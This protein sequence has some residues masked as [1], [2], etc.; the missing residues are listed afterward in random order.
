M[1][2]PVFQHIQIMSTLTHT[3]FTVEYALWFWNHGSVCLWYSWG[4][5]KQ[6][7]FF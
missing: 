7:N 5:Q 2:H 6:D 3:K 4:K 1:I